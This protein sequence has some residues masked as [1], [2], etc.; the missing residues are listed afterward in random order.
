MSYVLFMLYLTNKILQF[1]FNL[2]LASIYWLNLF[3]KQNYKSN[4]NFYKL[5]I[6]RKQIWQTGRLIILISIIVNVPIFNFR[7]RHFGLFLINSDTKLIVN[8]QFL[9]KR[10][11]IYFYKQSFHSCAS[12]YVW[13]VLTEALR[14]HYWVRP[15]C[16]SFLPS[17]LQSTF[18]HCVS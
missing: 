15:W 8:V 5:H 2:Q 4:T 18:Q 17:S 7:Y 9:I 6:Y 3:W 13:P 1:C 11:G 12:R 16:L 10:A 14:V